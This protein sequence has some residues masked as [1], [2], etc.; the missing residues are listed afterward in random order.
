MSSPATPTAVASLTPVIAPGITREVTTA[1]DR[2]T[3]SLKVGERFL[4]R[5]SDG[6]DWTV[7]VANESIVSRVVNVTVVEG[8]QGLYEARRPGQTT[9]RATGDPACRK[10]RPPCG[11][12]SR[13]F[14]VQ[15]V[16]GQ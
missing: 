2:Q 8:T 16:V 9:L 12:P 10:V 11:A 13:L 7:E 4:L 1:E 6:Y 14:E 5:L 15:I 3:I